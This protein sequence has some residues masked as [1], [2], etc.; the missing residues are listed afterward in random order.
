MSIIMSEIARHVLDRRGEQSTLLEVISDRWG[1]AAVRSRTTGRSCATNQKLLLATSFVML[2]LFPTAFA[3]NFT[4]KEHTVAGGG[5]IGTNGAFTIRGT[6][7]QPDASHSLSA[8]RFSVAGGFWSAFKAIA[9]P[10]V[11]VNP[12]VWT[13][14]AGG[15]WSVAANWSPNQ[16]PTFTNDVLITTNGTYTVTVN[17]NASARSVTLGGASGTQTLAV[18]NG[19][20]TLTAS[21]GIIVNPN[22]VL[23]LENGGNIAGGGTLVIEPGGTFIFKSTATHFASIHSERGHVPHSG[24]H[25][26]TCGQWHVHE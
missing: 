23:T 17:N 1:R 16:V 24:R 7:G 22:G 25:T 15:N 5:G 14:I 8:G 20:M 6:A 18:G 21:N 10:P 19:F 2:A 3:Q 26:H 4:I 11:P 9:T 13:N 12:L